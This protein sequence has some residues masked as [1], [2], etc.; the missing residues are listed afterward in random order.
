[1]SD[2]DWTRTYFTIKEIKEANKAIGH[3]WFSTGAM[4]FFDSRI[5]R[6]VIGGHYF[7]SSERFDHNTPRTYTVRVACDDGRVETEERDGERAEF[8]TSAAARA[9][10]KELARGPKS[11]RCYKY[12]SERDDD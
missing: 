10:V 11:S 4:R 9:Y 3:H 8:V 6:G 1:M 12:A 2:N 5:L 7:I